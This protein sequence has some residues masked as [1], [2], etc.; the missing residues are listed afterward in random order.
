MPKRQKFLFINSTAR[1]TSP[2]RNPDRLTIHRHVQLR[3]KRPS[4]GLAAHADIDECLFGTAF[5]IQ[6]QTHMQY[7]DGTSAQAQ[8]HKSKL[9]HSLLS[10]GTFDIEVPRPV[11]DP[12]CS[13]FVSLDCQMQQLL[14]YFTNEWMPA[15]SS[16]P[17]RCQIV[18]MTTVRPADGKTAFQ[19]MQGT[20]QNP[21]ETS[22]YALLTVCARRMQAHGISVNQAYLPD[23]YSVRAIRA[24]RR[25]INCGVKA[26]A[27]TVLDISFLLL[28]EFL[29]PSSTGCEIY[30]QMLRSVVIS[31]G[32]IQA[33]PVF[34][35]QI[36]VAYDSYTSA[37]GLL[38]PVLDLFTYP[39][40]LSTCYSFELPRELSNVLLT[41]LHCLDE[42]IQAHAV[43][44]HKLALLVED[45]QKLPDQALDHIRLY[46][47]SN[48][49]KL[50]AILCEPLQ[51]PGSGDCNQH[52]SYV[53]AADF[54]YF[55]IRFSTWRR[56]MLYYA[57]RN[58][59]EAKAFRFLLSNPLG[60][61]SGSSGTWETIIRIQ[62]ML[63]Q[64]GWMMDHVVVLWIAAVGYLTCDDFVVK[65]QYRE[66]LRIEAYEL[67]I[68]SVSHLRRAL[69]DHF[70][71]EPIN[72]AY[73][74]QLW[75]AI[76]CH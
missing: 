54:L 64:S 6:R 20:L 45:M 57:F 31:C 65:K 27:R 60:D 34:I 74:S 24:L 68:S 19:V 58:V 32:G 4:I 59:P 10:T 2:S 28:S 36:A 62:Q 52:S 47:R 61:T 16:I 12:I 69:S 25:N 46:L 73:D 26:S 71:L 56:W 13:R 67:R 30:R 18:G 21:D 3:A 70:S 50:H 41:R 7:G 8:D 39:E 23:I 22:L 48:L 37:G 29:A 72:S 43:E 40:L 35:A 15:S 5:G 42:R 38:K 66:M 55:R 33:I 49:D 75:A 63:Q 76:R 17:G 53:I 11:I 1:P 14:A 9:D 44:A 51:R